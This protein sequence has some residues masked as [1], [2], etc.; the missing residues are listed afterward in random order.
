MLEPDNAALAEALSSGQTIRLAYTLVFDWNRDG[1]FTGPHAD[2]SANLVEASLDEQFT[3]QYPAALEV[4]DGYAQNRLSVTVHGHIGPEAVHVVRFFSPYSGQPGGD[5]G[6]INTPARFSATIMTSAGPVE[7]RQ[8]TGYLLQAT[9]SRAKGTVVLELA[10]IT[11]Q[12]TN[13]ITLIPSGRSMAKARWNLNPT[14]TRNEAMRIRGGQL[15]SWYMLHIC[16]AAGLYQGPPAPAEA[17]WYSTLCGGNLPE[18][19]GFWQMARDGRQGN[20]ADQT[21]TQL[22]H[23]QP[24]YADNTDP[25]K[26]TSSP[27]STE[28][29]TT[30]EYPRYAWERGPFGPIMKRAVYD[31]AKTPLGP[32]GSNDGGTITDS[33]TG[34]Y[35][36]S[37]AIRI[38]PTSSQV[39][40]LGFGGYYLIDPSMPD[41][42]EIYARLELPGSNANWATSAIYGGMDMHMMA[43]GT[44]YISFTYY[45]PTGNGYRYYYWLTNLPAGNHYLAFN[46]EFKNG[47]KPIVTAKVDDRVF[48]RLPDQDVPP[49]YKD[50]AVSS[51]DA[52]SSWNISEYL[53]LNFVDIETNNFTF[54]Q[55]GG[56]QHWGLWYQ[57]PGPAS[58]PLVWSDAASQP[59]TTATDIGPSM[60][61]VMWTPAVRG[62]QAWDLLKEIGSADLGVIYTDE[63]GILHYTNWEE[64]VRARDTGRTTAVLSLADVQELDPTTLYESVIN[65]VSYSYADRAFTDKAVFA[66]E[67][68]DDFATASNTI[69]T[70]KTTISGEVISVMP[71]PL[72]WRGVAQGYPQNEVGGG[73]DNPGGYLRSDWMK[74]YPPNTWRN[75]FCVHNLGDVSTGSSGGLAVP[76]MGVG[77]N[78]VVG[79]GWG[80]GDTD[81]TRLTIQ[82]QNGNAA[83]GRTTRVAVD[84]NT[85]FLHVR[86]YALEDLDSGTETVTADDG[87]SSI[88][89]FGVRSLHRP[90]SDW[91]SDYNTQ[92]DLS[93]KLATDL[94]QPRP[95]FETTEIRGDP[96]RQLQDV[97][98]LDDPAG[99]GG[100]IYAT[101]VGINRKYTE[102]GITE[103]AT[104]RTFGPRGGSWILDDPDHSRLD[105]STILG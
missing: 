46:F 86:G 33:M 3:G 95:A 98:R 4:N 55:T 43:R 6:A 92:H 68:V 21:I 25:V 7:L 19:G 38:N 97:I 13:P 50:V 91:A 42:E 39:A 76:L 35:C 28:V 47:S 2:F 79:T 14:A 44:G 18:V 22:I 41:R 48:P 57:P 104:M 31:P 89:K 75:G 100:P 26:S 73:A 84:D 9:P 30:Y 83:G 62:R 99:I 81:P 93:V 88:A 77:V 10:D 101:V 12:L 67:N 27:A 24:S 52:P 36:T 90:Q 51:T 17:I 105:E 71:G 45:P 53:Q 29:D 82:V 60:A 94:A 59:F 54:R 32:W 74:A 96:R 66:S 103:T 23:D 78:I 61:R 11:S 16:R 8:F 87:G 15:L 85:P 69:A 49:E 5:V 56:A 72:T 64:I 37:T 65:T 1:T 80:A 63:H 20:A 40:R 102:H 34:V 70:Y 58:R